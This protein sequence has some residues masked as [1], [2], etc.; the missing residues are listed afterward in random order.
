VYACGL[1][2]YYEYYEYPLR[3]TTHPHRYKVTTT[4]NG[5]RYRL[6]SMYAESGDDE[7]IFQKGMCVCVCTA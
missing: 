1:S 3:H 7:L 5:N 2:S 6:R 4:G